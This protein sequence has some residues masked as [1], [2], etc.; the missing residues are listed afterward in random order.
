MMKTVLQ[1][2]GM[3]CGMCESHMND[4]VRRAFHVEKV[5]SSHKKKETVILSR[6]PLDEEKLRAVIAD[7]GYKVLNLTIEPYEKKSLFSKWFHQK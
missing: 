6:D 5:T 4:A 1:I 7:T 3:M 2:D